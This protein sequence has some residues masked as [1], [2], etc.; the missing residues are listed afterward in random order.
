ME[1]IIMLTCLYLP[2]LGSSLDTYH[3]APSKSAEG[4]HVTYAE[5]ESTSEAAVENV[6]ARFLCHPSSVAQADA[7]SLTET[8]TSRPE[9]RQWLPKHTALL[10][11]TSETRY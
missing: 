1:I 7:L 9:L 2:G 6:R 5:L 10:M 4:L 8:S 3:L 11:F